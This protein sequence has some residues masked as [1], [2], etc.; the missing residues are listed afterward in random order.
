MKLAKPLKVGGSPLMI[1]T[2]SSLLSGRMAK[3]LHRSV[4]R[5]VC[6]AARSFASSPKHDKPRKKI[7][8]MEGERV[9]YRVPRSADKTGLRRAENQTSQQQR[10]RN[11]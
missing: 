4:D 10:M 7:V 8:E 2:E 5:E 9:A 11:R 6:L 3:K 1:E